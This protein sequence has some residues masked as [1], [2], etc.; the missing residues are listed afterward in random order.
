[1]TIAP[2]VNPGPLNEW[3]IRVIGPQSFKN[4]LLAYFLDREVGMKCFFE[5]HYSDLSF[6]DNSKYTKHPQLALSDCEG[7]DCQ[8]LMEELKFYMVQRLSRNYAAL[9]NLGRGLEIEEE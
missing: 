3:V 9:F 1:M 5:K 8:R 2:F 6:S 7:K 4:E